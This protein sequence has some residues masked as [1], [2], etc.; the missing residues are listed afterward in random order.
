MSFFI[1]QATALTLRVNFPG[2]QTIAPWVITVIVPALSKYG[3]QNT[4]QC[5]AVIDDFGDL[6]PVTEFS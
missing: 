4:L 3:V 5:R 2:F 6:V 1:G